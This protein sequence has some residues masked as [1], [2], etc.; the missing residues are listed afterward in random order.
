MQH[1]EG[2]HL[3]IANTIVDLVQGDIKEHLP[4]ARIPLEGDVL[5]MGTTTSTDNGEL[6]PQ[7]SRL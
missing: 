3:T 2:I 6:L 1:S 5:G 7:G 4:V